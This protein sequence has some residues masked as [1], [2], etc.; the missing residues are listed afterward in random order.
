MH[1]GGV[2]FVGVWN[3]A[4]ITFPPRHMCCVDG[5][6]REDLCVC[7]SITWL[8]K[9]VSLHMLD[10]QNQLM[11][12]HSHG[13]TEVSFLYVCGCV[14]FP[15]PP[16]HLIGQFKH[17]TKHK[18]SQNSAYFFPSAGAFKPKRTWLGRRTWQWKQYSLNEMKSKAFCGWIL[19]I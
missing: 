8:S 1:V 19:V 6:G 11:P 3:G 5:C 9:T 2:F 17:R 7:V 4:S 15:P 12:L 14:P 10:A 18:Q 16:S 13:F